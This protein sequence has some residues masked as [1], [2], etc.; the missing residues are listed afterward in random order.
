MYA[1][2]LRVKGKWIQAETPG[3]Y[4]QEEG[5]S[6]S[7]AFVVSMYHVTVPQ[8]VGAFCLHLFIYTDGLSNNHGD[9]GFTLVH[10]WPANNGVAAGRPYG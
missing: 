5:A 6:F 4:L 7:L 3:R 8:V 2:A 9:I 10:P 1:I